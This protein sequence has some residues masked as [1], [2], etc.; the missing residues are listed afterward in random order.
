M[1][2]LPA[3]VAGCVADEVD[4]LLTIVLGYTTLASLG[5]APDSDAEVDLRIATEAAVRARELTGRLH[6]LAGRRVVHLHRVELAPALLDLRPRLEQLLGQAI[7][8]AP[9]DLPA[10]RV[11]V[12]P[13]LLEQ[14]VVE[15]TT[16]AL[17]SLDQIGWITL[18]VRAATLGDG[19][20]AAAIVVRD[21]GH[22]M[23]A[24]QLAGCQ[25][26][27][28]G[29]L[30]TSGCGLG[31]AV[32]GRA[33]AMLDGEVWLESEPGRGTTATAVLPLV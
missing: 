16:N 1:S 29:A 18:S 21:T 9:D 3:E 33:I 4:H 10:A 24:E 23:D 22:G 26:V 20:P 14:V 32:A 2:A 17:E 19:R 15:L 28:T 27:L 30:P 6:T 5:L 25:A 12:D 8:L 31:L 13:S 7:D 11:N